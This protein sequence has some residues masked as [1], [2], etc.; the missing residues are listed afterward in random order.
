VESPT[1]ITPG[2]PPQT[3]P[4]SAAASATPAKRTTRRRQPRVKVQAPP[5]AFDHTG[6]ADETTLA[7]GALSYLFHVPALWIVVTGLLAVVGVGAW[8]WDK[9]QH[10]GVTLYAV[11]VCAAAFTWIW[12]V[13]AHS[14]WTIGAI[15]ALLAGTFALGPVYARLRWKHDEANRKEVAARIEQRSAEQRHE[16]EGILDAA[17][18]KDI[19]VDTDRDG[20]QQGKREF[21]AG[22]A[23]ALNLGEK[24]P[25]VQ[26]MAV[27]IPK[28]EKIASLRTKHSIRPGSL[29]VHPEPLAA[30]QCEIVVPI[31]DILAKDI[32]AVL[33]KGPRPYGGPLEVMTSVDGTRLGW[34]PSIDIHGMV[35][36]LTGAGKSV[37]L[38]AHLLEAIRTREYVNWLQCGAKP[39]RNLMGWLR[40]FLEGTIHPETGQPVEPVI[41]WFAADLEEAVCQLLD[42]MVLVERR[43]ESAGITGHDK[44]QATSA[45]PEVILWVDESPNFL[46]SNRKFETHRQGER[47]TYSEML[48]EAARLARSEG[49]HVF[50]LT[51]R[52][53]VSMNGGEA[54][55]LKSQITYRAG[56]HATGLI[57]ANAVFN[58]VTA[59][60]NV[61]TLRIGELYVE[62]S[63][64]ARPILAKGDKVDNALKRQAAVEYSPYCGPLDDWTAE[65]LTF[66]ADRWTRLNQQEF[67][68]L[69][70][71]GAVRTI[72]GQPARSMPP[73]VAFGQWLTERYG[74]EE[75]PDDQLD[76]LFAEFIGAWID[77]PADEVTES[78]SRDEGPP[79]AMAGF[80]AWV[81]ENYPGQTPT[82]DMLF[83][84]TGLQVGDAVAA[85]LRDQEI[86]RRAKDVAALDALY[87]LE[88]EPPP[89]PEP[90]PTITQVDPSLPTDTRAVLEV[91]AG[92]DLVYSNQELTPTAEVT[93]LVDAVHGWGTNGAGGRRVLQ[94]LRVVNVF[95]VEPRPRIAGKK[96][97]CFRTADLVQA[98]E[99]N[100]VGGDSDG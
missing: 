54:G 32:P 75:L 20:Y 46:G 25:E 83:K 42:F 13:A 19:T 70:C 44:W 93:A 27:L 63:G 81:A 79:D 64:Y 88:Y 55:D 34:D 92:S 59:G 18:A 77:M 22:F 17:G 85:G 80:N 45:N 94:A 8:S 99:V 40:P 87:D 58:T 89:P 37:F 65:A 60:I 84:F 31:R 76:E 47:M 21:P 36:G 39:V 69:L 53:T 78:S 29:Q 15:A 14:P 1:V 95:K 51:Q 12:W 49:G 52:G 56:F 57:D 5:K 33:H 90:A 16:W 72:P 26:G 50:F 97:E 30:H 86:D 41:D 43:Q 23:L 35:A 68:M 4:Q 2:Q 82:D 98:V 10:R 28:I 61:E 3:P 100:T 96:T 7:L 91:I 73:V 6:Y 74:E 67:L 66:Y 24:A 11:G 62:M 38:D 48:L 71:P 9:F